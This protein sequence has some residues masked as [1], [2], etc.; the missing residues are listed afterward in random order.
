MSAPAIP[1]LR[2]MRVIPFRPRWWERLLRWATR[3]RWRPYRTITI[4]EAEFM[5]LHRPSLEAEGY[6]YGIQLSWG[7]DTRFDSDHVLR[8]TMPSDEADDAR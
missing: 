7:A 5:A 6:L 4:T 3:G 8:I 1:R 2:R